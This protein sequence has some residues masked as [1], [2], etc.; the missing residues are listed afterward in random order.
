MAGGQID[1]FFRK[2]K[3][4]QPLRALANVDNLNRVANVLNDI[5][6]EGCTIDKPTDGSP[7]TISYTGGNSDN[8][9]LLMPH[10]IEVDIQAANSAIYR[11]QSEKLIWPQRV[12]ISVN[13]IAVVG[14][15]EMRRAW[16]PTAGLKYL[17]IYQHFSE[18]RKD[19][20]QQYISPPSYLYAT[21]PDDAYYNDALIAKI[22][23]CRAE[24]PEVGKPPKIKCLLEGPLR[25]YAYRGDADQ[26]AYAPTPPNPLQ[27][28]QK[29]KTVDNSSG[30]ELPIKVRNFSASADGFFNEYPNGR[31]RIIKTEEGD[32]VEWLEPD[33]EAQAK[34][35]AKALLLRYIWHDGL[36]M[37]GLPY[38]FNVE[39]FKQLSDSWLEE[40]VLE[41]IDNTTP[42]WLISIL[43]PWAYEIYNEQ[44]GPYEEVCP[45]EIDGKEVLAAVMGRDGEW[46]SIVDIVVLEEEFEVALAEWQDLKDRADAI[47]DEFENASTTVDHVGEN[48]ATIED[49]VAH[50]VEDYDYSQTVSTWEAEAEMESDSNA[51]MDSDF[52]DLDARITALEQRIT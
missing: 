34:N 17:Y 46:K 29:S 14:A 47:N 18:Y 6:G 32:E 35:E 48:V 16:Q 49:E 42:T 51:E 26:R 52:S 3:P 21:S 27:Q 23:Y 9:P 44:P 28:I 45:F 8:E 19:A 4:G 1:G 43:T 11:E 39:A 41:S 15:S 2:V 25:I 36:I 38:W 7:W 22:P 5:S 20:E 33:E 12:D 10:E 13:G 30:G 37:H 40:Y 24:I 31:Y 50:L